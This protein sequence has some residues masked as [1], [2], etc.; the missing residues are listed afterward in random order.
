MIGAEAWRAW[1]IPVRAEEEPSGPVSAADL[2]A[3]IH[4][5]QRMSAYFEDA[6][7]PM[8]PAE[9]WALVAILSIS[10]ALVIGGALLIAT[11]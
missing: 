3:S 9:G 7:P 11:Y 10:A 5:S 6:R 4:T 8:S 2:D 1:G